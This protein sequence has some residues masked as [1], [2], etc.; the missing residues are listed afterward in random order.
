MRLQFTLKKVDQH[1]EGAL[2]IDGKFHRSGSEISIELLFDKYVEP[3]LN[4]MDADE[5]L[6]TAE[7]SKE[8]NAAV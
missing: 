7:I 6:F 3:I 5:V 2:F 8:P 4:N 1:F